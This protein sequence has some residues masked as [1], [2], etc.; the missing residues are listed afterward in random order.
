MVDVL[1]TVDDD[2]F[3]IITPQRRLTAAKLVLTTGGQS[4]PGCGTTGDGY[5]WAA[6]FG[7]AVIP[8]RPALVPLTDPQ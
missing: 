4:Y 7:H 8:P 6:Q 5:T 2:V 3:S 1:R